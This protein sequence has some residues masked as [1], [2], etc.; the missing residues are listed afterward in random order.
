MENKTEKNIHRVEDFHQ[1][2][3]HSLIRPSTMQEEVKSLLDLPVDIPKV[4]I[5]AEANVSAALSCDEE[6]DPSSCFYENELHRTTSIYELA[7][8]FV[9]SGLCAIFE[10]WF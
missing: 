6:T 10:N 3:V 2:E 7:A 8:F 5:T 1:E 4:R 9:I